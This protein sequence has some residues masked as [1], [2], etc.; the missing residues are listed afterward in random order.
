MPRLRIREDR[1]QTNAENLKK[2]RAK[3]NVIIAAFK[4]QGCACG[5]DHPAALD[6][7]HRDPSTKHDK[8]RVKRRSIQDLT[9]AELAAEL[10][11]CDVICANCHRKAHHAPA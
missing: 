2:V 6:L 9:F 4:A 11:K 8:L 7:H 3:K 10:A 1:L 5:E